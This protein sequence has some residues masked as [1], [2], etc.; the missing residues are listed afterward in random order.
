MPK[1]SR[2]LLNNR[3]T[4]CWIQR[5][6]TQ[7]RL[8][9]RPLLAARLLCSRIQRARCSAIKRPMVAPFHRLHPR[10]QKRCPPVQSLTWEGGLLTSS[11]ARSWLALSSPVHLQQSRSLT[12]ALP[13]NKQI[14]LKKAKEMVTS[15]LIWTRVRK[16]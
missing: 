3:T 4:N 11:W 2:R 6:L 12:S 15:R 8:P 7:R 16:G 10:T 14:S 9:P 5:S 1:I 13:S